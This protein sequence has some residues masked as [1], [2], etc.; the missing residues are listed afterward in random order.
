MR[1]IA[2]HVRAAVML[3]S[4]GV[5]PGNKEQGYFS[6]R[7]LRRAIRYGKMIGIDKPFLADLVPVVAAIY[8]E[9]YPEVI[10]QAQ[11]I[12]EVFAAEE[13]KF[14]KTLEVG[15]RQFK[16]RWLEGQKNQHSADGKQ[17][18]IAAVDA[19][20]LYQ[21]YGFPVE[22]TIEIAQQ[23]SVALQPANPEEFLKAFE[24]A[25]TEHASQSRTASAGKFKGGLAEHTHIT[26][27]YHTATHLL[28]AALR[29]ILGMHVQQQGSN[30]TDQRLRF[31]FY[32]SK[33]PEKEDVEKVSAII[34]KKI[35]EK[36]PMRFKIM[37]KDEAL[38]IGARSFFKEKYPDQVKV[39]YIGGE[40]DKPQTAYSKEFCGGPHVK[41]TSEIGKIEIYKFEK[42]G[43]NLY[44][45]YAR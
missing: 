32:S 5:V 9:A 31:D 18:Y 3:A 28:Q 8:S 23:E 15:L 37:P 2:D 41:N 34:N 24:Q 40:D 14:R 4:D 38:K 17:Y 7:L 11:H 29:Q 36:L 25:K 20:D 43:S 26:T 13:T 27:Q 21:T 44:R 1:V 45:F 16:K 6:R 12:T 22:L 35:E 42:I 30:I 10:Q 39:Y 19:F 33:K